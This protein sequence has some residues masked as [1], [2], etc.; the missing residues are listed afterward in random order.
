MTAVAE[1][2]LRPLYVVGANSRLW[3]DVGLGGEVIPVSGRLGDVDRLPEVSDGSV[4][5]VFADPPGEDATRAMLLSLLARLRQGADVRVIHISSIS[6]AFLA[7]AAFPHEGAYARRKRL[8]EEVLATRPDLSV[9]ILRVGNV[10]SHGGWQAVRAHARAILLPAGFEGTAVSEPS[11]VA[12]AIRQAMAL[13]AGHHLVQAWHVA[14][15]RTLFARVVPVPGLLAIY[16]HRVMRPMLKVLGR[17]LR[18][19]GW[20]LPSPD[21]LNAFLQPVA[22]GREPH[23]KAL[24]R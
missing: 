1:C 22:P 17:L 12:V 19:L 16:S 11:D 5:L 10:F 2:A 3:R 8:A 4:L 21:D 7:S 20:F 6:A 15:T 14:P 13:P 9:C 18:P 24:P 23:D